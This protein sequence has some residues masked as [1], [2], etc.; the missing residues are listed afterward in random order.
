M[1]VSDGLLGSFSFDRNGDISESPITIVQVRRRTPS[2]A[3]IEGGA[4]VRVVRPSASLVAPV[5]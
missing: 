5:R 4:V 2:G 3:A 1:R